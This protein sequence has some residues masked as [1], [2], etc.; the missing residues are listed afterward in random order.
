MVRYKLTLAYDGTAFYGSQKQ[1]GRRTV[2][3]ELETA[4]RRLGWAGGR[5]IM[6]GRTD[7]GVHAR[8]QV[9]A[10]DLDW[11]RTIPGLRSALN[12]LLPTDMAVARVDVVGESF[13]PRFDACSRRYEY[14]IR[15]APERD[16]FEERFA[17]RLW[18]APD[19]EI[20]DVLADALVGGHDFGAFGSAPKKGGSTRRTVRHAGWRRQPGS[21]LFEIVA[22]GFLYR[23][24][25]RLVYVQVAAAQGRCP[26]SAVLGA[27]R[28]RPSTPSLVTGLAPASG[29]VLANVAYEEERAPAP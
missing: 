14:N 29:L 1:A 8:G 26:K 4:M 16:P 25:R 22:D 15:I 27:L 7:A 18:P 11:R 5:V 28:G 6:A 2:Q 9:A 21:L 20:L 23:M 10:V 17:W 12:G 24:V 13:H 19:L 3:S